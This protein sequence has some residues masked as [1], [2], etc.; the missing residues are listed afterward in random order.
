MNELKICNKC[1][2]S[3]HVSCFSWRSERRGVRRKECKKCFSKRT[4]EH[5]R[6]NKQDYARRRDASRKAINQW[7]IWLKEGT[8]CTDCGNF[9]PACVMEFD[10]IDDNKLFNISKF[11]EHTKTIADIQNE[12]MKCE[13]VCAN[14]HRIRTNIHRKEWHRMKSQPYDPEY[15]FSITQL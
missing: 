12:I 8:P 6:N 7:L 15:W 9:Y 3:L 11:H 2:E 13:L 10:H 5:Y 1:G 14:C 4:R